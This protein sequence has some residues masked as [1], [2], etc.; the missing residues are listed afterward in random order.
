MLL[1]S[2]KR[3]VKAGQKEG[4]CN[5]NYVLLIFSLGIFVTVYNVS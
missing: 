5:S 4:C 2:S 1:S 3:I